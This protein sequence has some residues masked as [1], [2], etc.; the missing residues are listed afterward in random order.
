M[1]KSVVI[2]EVGPRDGLQ[3]EAQPISLE[4]KFKIIEGLVAAGLERIEVGAFVSPQW[5]PQMQGSE[6]VVKQ[7]FEKFK[8]KDLRFSALVPNM[9][10]FERAQQT[11]LKEMAVFG[12]CTEAFSQKNINCSIDESFDHFAEIIKKGKASKIWFRGYLSMAFGC[13][14]EGFVSPK[15]VVKLAERLLKLGVQE[16]SIGDTIGVANPLQVKKLVKDLKTVVPLKKLA[17]H[18]HDTRGTALA[19][20]ESSLNEGVRI[21]DSSVGG[22]GGCPYAKGASGN[23][24]TDDLVYMLDGMGMKTGVDLKKLLEVSRI[25]EGAVGHKLPSKVFQAGGAAS[26]IS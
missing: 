20:V 10:G 26:V 19:N 18:F 9:K 21:F 7:V 2:Q 15:K 1:S 12:S 24:A 3:N 11:P 16:V 23:L 13:P 14:Y 8:K 5:V 17:M 6:H 4:A 22:L 25:A